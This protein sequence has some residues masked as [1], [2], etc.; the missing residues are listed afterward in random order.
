[1]PTWPSVP[2]YFLH[3]KLM[4]DCEIRAE[5][6]KRV[7]TYKVRTFYVGKRGCSR[8]PSGFILGGRGRQLRRGEQILGLEKGMIGSKYFWDDG[9]LREHG[10]TGRRRYCLLYYFLVPDRITCFFTPSIQVLHELLILMFGEDSK[11][12]YYS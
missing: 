11:Q 7:I 6:S 8:C 5:H 12:V 3:N 9:M 1:M 2:R 10:V 4:C